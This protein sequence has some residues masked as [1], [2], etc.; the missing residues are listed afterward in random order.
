MNDWQ[1]LESAITSC[2]L[3]PRLVAWREEVARVKRRAYRDEDYWGK[4]VPGFG[5]PARARAGDRVWRPPHTAPI[6]RAACSPATA[7][8]ISCTRRCI[9]PGSPASRPPRHR[10]DGLTLTDAFISARCAAARRRTT[11]RRRTSSPR[12]GPSWSERSRC[13]PT[14]GSWW[15]WAGWPSTPCCASSPTA[16]DAADPAPPLPTPRPI[17]S[18]TGVG[19]SPHIIPAARTPRPA[20]SPPRCSTRCGRR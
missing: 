11:S 15:R 6:A 8:A 1:S 4:P 20:V 16:E 13:C 2:R 18:R 9:A 12:A 19:W 7:P 14:C 17:R 3:C 10:D 5:D